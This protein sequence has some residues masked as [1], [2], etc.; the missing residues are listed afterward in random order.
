MLLVNL[1]L[2]PILQEKE[3]AVAEE[4]QLAAR[5]LQVLSHFEK[6]DEILLPTLIKSIRRLLQ[7][8]DAAYDIQRAVLSFINTSLSKATTTD[9][10]TGLSKA[11]TDLSDNKKTANSL[12][13]FNY[14]VW[15]QAHAQAFPFSKAWHMNVTK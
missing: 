13:L 6:K 8:K 12:N 2:W 5:M 11:T 1:Y 9:K 3:A 15:A 7:D 4:V 10:W 14:N